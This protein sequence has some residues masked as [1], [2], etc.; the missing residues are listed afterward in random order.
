MAS[1]EHARPLTIVGS[2]GRSTICPETAR[3]SATPG[4]AVLVVLAFATLALTLA[5][6][7]AAAGEPSY[8]YRFGVFPYLPVLT[9]DQLF[10]PMALSFAEVLER[11][12]YLKTKSTF[13]RFADELANRTYDIVLVHPFF[14]VEAADQYH[15][16]PLVRVDAKLTAV[17]MVA[18]E[19]PWTSWR[20]LAG[21][22]LAL[23]PDLSA[24]SQLVKGA[25]ID[26]GLWPDV[27]LTLE[28]YGTKMSCLQAVVSGSADACAVPRF[29]ISQ[30]DRIAEMNLRVMA[31]TEP[32]NHFVI[33]VHDR[34]PQADRAKLLAD[35]LSWPSSPEG[36]A[37]LAAGAWPGFLV[38]EDA[39]YDEIR[40]YRSRLRTLAQ[41]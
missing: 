37:I 2:T 11:P 3:R 12:V 13:E 5:P 21:R 24:V 39:E 6:R 19:R 27:D 29:L 9:I 38:A 40:R 4:V 33:A 31:E 22:T 41:R 7:S 32:I 35:I 15:Y 23:P 20:D 10:G 17:A 26:A 25:L 36:Q 28:Y 8:G 1:L 16:Q 30:I 18:I 14:Y 34:V